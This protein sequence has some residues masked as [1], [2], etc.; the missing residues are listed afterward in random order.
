MSQILKKENCT[1]EWEAPS[2]ATKAYF[3]KIKNYNAF[4]GLV[5]ELILMTILW[6]I[7]VGYSAM[8]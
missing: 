6:W 5:K 4:V 8:G 7:E 3:I 2:N 1:I